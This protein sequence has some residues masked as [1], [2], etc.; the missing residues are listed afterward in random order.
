MQVKEVATALHTAASALPDSSTKAHLLR[1]LSECAAALHDRLSAA[2]GPSQADATAVASAEVQP[3]RPKRAKRSKPAANA[4]AEQAAEA[5]AAGSAGAP[6]LL[7]GTLQALVERS[8]AGS[9]DPSVDPVALL[10]AR[11]PPPPGYLNSHI[12]RGYPA[13]AGA[14]DDV[15]AILAAADAALRSCNALAGQGGHPTTALAAFGAAVSL[16]CRAAGVMEGP[17]RSA[18][19]QQGQG[20][21]SGPQEWAQLEALGSRALLCMHAAA[22]EARAAAAA[23][24][25]GGGAADSASRWWVQW[26]KGAQQAEQE[27]VEACAAVVSLCTTARLHAAAAQPEAAADRA[28]AALAALDMRRLAPYAAAGQLAYAAEAPLEEVAR[29]RDGAR[30]FLALYAAAAE[31]GGCCCGCA[32]G[33]V[34]GGGGLGVG[35]GGGGLH[36]VASPLYRAV[37]ITGGRR[38]TDARCRLRAG[39]EAASA[40]LYLLRMAA[41]RKAAAVAS[42][43]GRLPAAAA[44]EAAAAATA[45]PAEVVEWLRQQPPSSV[46]MAALSSLQQGPSGLSA[47]LVHHASDRAV[48]ALAAAVQSGSQRDGGGGGEGV[49]AGGGEGAPSAADDLLFFVSREGDAALLGE[50]WGAD[51]DSGAEEGGSGEGAGLVL[52]ELPDF[53]AGASAGGGGRSDDGGSGAE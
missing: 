44:L 31:Q 25:G 28:L 43:I 11:F 21:H 3:T 18:A 48:L 22:E 6:T 45:A 23:G 27:A 41:A 49:D 7:D 35:V 17:T 13:A 19:R 53:E 29:G 9:P 14:S 50:G 4:P 10:V 8:L 37:H 12:L 24:E 30:C 51:A 46:V 34:V 26:A 36:E 20:Q 47:H 16:M 33:V 1:N 40:E 39:A 42:A 15:P 32:W 52:G 2:H 5:P 38:V